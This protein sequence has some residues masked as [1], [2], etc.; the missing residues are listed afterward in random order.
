[1]VYVCKILPKHEN[2]TNYSLSHVFILNMN[3]GYNIFCFSDISYE[4]EY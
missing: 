4:C 2:K 1:M 3:N